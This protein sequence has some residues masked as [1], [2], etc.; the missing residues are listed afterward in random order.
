MEN[1]AGTD[2]NLAIARPGQRAPPWCE[3]FCL[4]LKIRDYD[5]VVSI[6]S[7]SWNG[8][9]PNMRKLPARVLR[10]ALE[11]QLPY[12][13]SENDRRHAQAAISQLKTQERLEARTSSA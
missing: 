6:A 2:P 12:L 10:C 11:S 13:H 4:L 9:E 8:I 5:G 1:Y 7:T 3:V